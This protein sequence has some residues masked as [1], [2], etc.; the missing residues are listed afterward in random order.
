MALTSF[1][2]G[3][4][5]PIEFTFMFLAPAALCAARGAHGRRR[6]CSC[7]CSACTWDSASPPAC[8]TTCST[9]TARRGRWLLLP[10]GLAYFAV[11]YAAFRFFIRAF[12]LK[13]PGREADEVVI[14]DPATSG[15]RG[16]DF[17]AALGGAANLLSVDACTTRLRLGIAQQ[18]AV[19]AEA[20]KRLGARGLVRP[21]QNALQV[22]LGPIADQ[23]ADEIRSAMRAPSVSSGPAVS[24]PVRA[25]ELLKALGG[26]DNLQTVAAAAGRVLVTIVEDS[27]VNEAALRA[28][29]SRGVARPAPGRVQLPFGKAAG[30]ISESLRRLI[31]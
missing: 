13:T 25:A 8:S 16:R 31:L 24:E 6:W 17:L 20:L 22:V 7:T 15:H 12:N 10:V 19:D 3:V 2:T 14:A 30:E 27:K 21:A 28:L 4:T 23:V 9:S 1:L 29:G 26:R 11:Y 5:E 18:A